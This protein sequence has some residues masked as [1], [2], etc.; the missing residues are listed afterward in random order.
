MTNF[1]LFPVNSK[2]TDTDLE[3][4]F[5]VSEN[6]FISSICTLT[7]GEGQKYSQ[8]LEN[9]DIFQFC[10]TFHMNFFFSPKKFRE[11][12]KSRYLAVLVQQSF[13]GSN[14]DVNALKLICLIPHIYKHHALLKKNAIYASKTFLQSVRSTCRFVAP[15]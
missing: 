14:L 13:S 6:I 7:G 5:Q 1:W 10:E 3:C 12:Q 9:P 8:F 4:S 11:P 2:Q 15:E